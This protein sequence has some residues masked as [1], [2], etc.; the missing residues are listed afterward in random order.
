MSENS[1]LLLEPLFPDED[2]T[3]AVA[4]ALESANLADS[5]YGELNQNGLQLIGAV[6]DYVHSLQVW[7][8][9]TSAENLAGLVGI[10][11]SQIWGKEAL[12][13]LTQMAN[14]NV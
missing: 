5:A 10:L 12:A 2:N 6:R 11:I 9:D 14:S 3:M 4:Y 7:G 1:E 8:Q 13:L